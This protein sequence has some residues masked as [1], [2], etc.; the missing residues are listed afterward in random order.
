MRLPHRRPEVTLPKHKSI[1]PPRSIDELLATNPYPKVD[2]AART[3]AAIQ[4]K[5]AVSAIPPSALRGQATPGLSRIAHDVFTDLELG[6]FGVTSATLFVSRLNS[7]TDALLAEFPKRARH[8]GV[9]RKAVNLFLRDA[10]YNQFLATKHGLARAAAHY[11]LPLD[12]LTATHL[13]DRDDEWDFPKWRGVKWLT[14]ADSAMYQ[15]AAQNMA[16]EYGCVR[17]H[18]DAYIWAR[19]AET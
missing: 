1:R 10:Y 4:R 13:D 16:E 3:L 19:R 2:P 7:C 8:W 5:V 15:R 14:R 9:A 11:E 6:Q 18:L 12:R 17:V